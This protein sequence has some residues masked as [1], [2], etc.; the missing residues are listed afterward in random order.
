MSQLTNPLLKGLKP[1]YQLQ[2]DDRKKPIGAEI[3]MRSPLGEI[4][5][6]VRNLESSDAIHNLDLLAFKYALQW[7]HQHK[8]PCASN[9][10]GKSLSRKQ[11]LNTILIEGCVSQIKIELTENKSLNFKAIANIEE[12]SGTGFLIS[13]DDYGSQYNG[14]NRL[15]SLP[16]KEIKIDRYLIKRLEG[17]KARAIVESTIKLG[18]NIGCSVVAEGVESDREY[19][20][21]LE[22][23]CTKFQGFYLHEPEPFATKC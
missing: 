21:L 20:I 12:L 22:L 5:E 9:F 13:L 14:L 18:Q 23:G 17:K 19:D 6:V 15:S 3:L 1:Y 11:I 7:H 16:I 10:S 4:T 8:L 2:F